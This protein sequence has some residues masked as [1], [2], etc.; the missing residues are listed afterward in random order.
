[1]TK[2]QKCRIAICN[3]VLINL[4]HVISRTLGPS[5]TYEL[6]VAKARNKQRGNMAKNK[7][8]GAGDE[9]SYDGG[10]VQRDMRNT[11]LTG[12]SLKLWQVN[13]TLCY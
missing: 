8:K 13:V 4:I 3:L 5:V 9:A 11:L 1:M 2:L 12:E 7:G 10:F 6:Y